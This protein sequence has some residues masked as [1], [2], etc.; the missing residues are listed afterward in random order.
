MLLATATPDAPARVINTS[1][2]LSHLVSSVDFNTVKESPKRK[3]VGA[4]KLYGQSKFVSLARHTR[5]YQGAHAGSRE[6]SSS[7][8]SWHADLGSRISSLSRS[9][10]ETSGRICS[11]T[12]GALCAKSW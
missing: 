9:I 11:A 8:T 1:S 3:K 2:F 5:D 10:P 12:L 4:S 7:A 6:T